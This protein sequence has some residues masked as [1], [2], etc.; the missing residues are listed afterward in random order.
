MALL[1]HILSYCCVYCVS[2]QQRYSCDS[3]MNL[4]KYPMYPLV[5]KQVFFIN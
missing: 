5:V 1:V 4:N 3:Q 2:N